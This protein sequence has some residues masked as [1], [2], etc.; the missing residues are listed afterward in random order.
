[1]ANCAAVMLIEQDEKILVVTRKDG[2]FGLPGGKLEGDETFFRAAIRETF[3]ETNVV[4][5]DGMYMFHTMDEDGYVVFY[6]KSQD[7]TPVK[8]FINNEG[9]EVKLVTFEEL[10]RNT[11]YTSLAAIRGY[12][13]NS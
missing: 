6:F 13:C 4:V 2:T 8:E 11:K 1:M 7:N 5:N 3:E 10:M 12:L 9:Q